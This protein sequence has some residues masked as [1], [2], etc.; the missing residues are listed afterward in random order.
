[1]LKKF[2]H[3]ENGSITLF[4][5]LAILFFLIVIFSIFVAS[6]NKQQSQN[7]EID[8][9]KKEYAQSVHDIDQIYK[10]TVLDNLPNLI[11]I[12]DYV[13]YTYDTVSDGYSLP[14]TQS[15]Y[16]SNQTIKQPNTPLNWRILNIDKENGTM[17]LISET[18]TNQLVYLNGALGYNNGVYL[19]NDIC[20]TLYSNHNVNISARSLNIE[21][22]ENQ[23]NV[24]GENTKN[25][26]VNVESKLQYGQTK[27]YGQIGSETENNTYYPNL[28]AKEN[29]SGINTTTTKQDGIDNSEN[30]YTSPTSDTSTLADSLTVTQTFYYFK[31]TP[32]NSCF[33]NSILYDMVF[34]PSTQYFLASRFSSCFDL[35]ASFGLF[36]VN[37]GNLSAAYIFSSGS[38]TSAG[39][40]SNYSGRLRPVV[41]VNI[42]QI[43]PCT[44]TAADGKD[45][46][47][48]HMHQIKGIYE[49]N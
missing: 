10:S 15:G 5:L 20:K 28:Y 9:I 49:A 36:R 34:N 8:K 2:F 7:S 40:S 26:Y 16:T 42:D 17:D 38:G 43:L 48:E 21:D 19:L 24:T 35:S 1:M 6:S 46:T 45:K 23:M 25:T 32:A 37:N 13:N 11:K 22:I 30:G 14:S 27:T 31:T 41:T 29:T 12:G 47:I 4:I 3:K 18:V 33:D 44:G 39:N